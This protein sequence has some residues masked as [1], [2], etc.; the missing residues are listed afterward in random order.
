[1]SDKDQGFKIYEVFCS[2]CEID[3]QMNNLDFLTN[4]VFFSHGVS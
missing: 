4:F 3:I 2:S 1:M